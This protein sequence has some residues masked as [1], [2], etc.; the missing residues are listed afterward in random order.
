VDS[1][2]R[3]RTATSAKPAAIG[4]SARETTRR[5]DTRLTYR[6][7]R[8]VHCAQ[9]KKAKTA[10]SE[11]VAGDSALAQP[12]KA[13]TAFP[14]DLLSGSAIVA[15]DGGD[16]FAIVGRAVV[17]FE[18]AV[19][20]VTAAEAA[21]HAFANALEALAERTEKC[22]LDLEAFANE[23]K[24]VAHDLAHEVTGKAEAAAAAEQKAKGAASNV[25]EAVVFE[26]D[27]FVVRHGVVSCV[28]AA[29]NRP[30][31]LF[32]THQRGEVL[33]GPPAGFCGP[34]AGIPG[35]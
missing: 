12:S 11:C 10:C 30:R 2:G 27:Q 25:H 26:R 19:T 31:V 8:G 7:K 16:V 14:E 17:L 21:V 28:S 4:R 1:F 23:L 15:D 18:A 5:S 29:P 33:T 32:P 9:L 20:A 24:A 34:A 6:K 35:G 22:A 13:R 3:C